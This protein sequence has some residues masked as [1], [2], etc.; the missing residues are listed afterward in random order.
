MAAFFRDTYFGRIARAV[1]DWEFLR[2]NEE[3]QRA[4]AESYYLQQQAALTKEISPDTDV[5]H[6]EATSGQWLEEKRS[7]DG[8]KIYVVSFFGPNDPEVSR[9]AHVGRLLTNHRAASAQLVAS[10]EMLR[11]DGDLLLD[12]FRV[13]G[14]FTLVLEHD[15]SCRVF[16]D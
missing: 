9:P 7:N 3:R 15:W 1:Y 13:H 12:C 2:Y 4:F 5:A 11:D 6:E 10:Q 14:E 8:D 16:R